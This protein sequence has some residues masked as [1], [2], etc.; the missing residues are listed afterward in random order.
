MDLAASLRVIATIPAIT[1]S[2][3][4]VGPTGPFV[5]EKE[6][7]GLRRADDVVYKQLLAVC[8]PIQRLLRVL[9]TF[10]A[11]QQSHSHTSSQDKKP[12]PLPVLPSTVHLVYPVLR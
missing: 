2:T 11:R 8:S 12:S 5:A 1:A 10:V 3:K 7:Q 6:G 4:K 9:Q